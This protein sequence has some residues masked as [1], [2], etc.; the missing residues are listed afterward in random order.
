VLIRRAPP[1]DQA[2]AARRELPVLSELNPAVR[3]N[4]LALPSQAR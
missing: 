3:R 4:G 2:G 1:I